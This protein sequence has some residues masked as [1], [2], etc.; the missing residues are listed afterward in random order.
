MANK[1]ESNAD[2]TFHHSRS[3]TDWNFKSICNVPHDIACNLNFKLNNDHMISLPFTFIIQ[4]GNPT[5]NGF[6]RTEGHP[7]IREGQ[8]IYEYSHAFVGICK[9]SQSFVG[10]CRYSRVF[11]SIPSIC[12]RLQEYVFA[13]VKVNAP[14]F[15]RKKKTKFKIRQTNA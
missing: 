7:S 4:H 15:E 5:F 14:R 11:A 2:C 3:T 1:A 12:G 13:F 10:I 8:N 6:A 9:H